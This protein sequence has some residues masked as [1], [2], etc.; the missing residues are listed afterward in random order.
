M[1]KLITESIATVTVAKAIKDKAL[2]AARE[3]VLPGTY[4]IDTTVRVHGT[5][6]V[7]ED[8]EQ[9]YPIAIPWEFLTLWLLNKVNPATAE[10]LLGE[11]GDYWEAVDDR[12]AA[13]E[14]LRETVKPGVYGQIEAL[15]EET[16]RRVKGKVT[17][18][19][20]VEPVEAT[21]SAI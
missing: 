4:A 17:T 13:I 18:D 3:R 10:K 8:G 5:I 14:D 21:V 19:L 20:A 7:G 16:V 2:K 9:T 15:K 1:N 12:T 6:T 11:A